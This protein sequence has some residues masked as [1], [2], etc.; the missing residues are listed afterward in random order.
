MSDSTEY[1]R[2][3]SLIRTNPR[4]DMGGALLFVLTTLAS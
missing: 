3:L 4:V 2:I 1:P